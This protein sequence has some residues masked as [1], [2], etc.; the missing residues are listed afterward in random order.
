[1]ALSLAV[2]GIIQTYI[3]RILGVDYLT[4]QGFMKLW[5]TA[6]WVSAWGFTAGLAAFLV[7]FFRRL[8]PGRA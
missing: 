3:Q 1:M 7:D 2:A 6:F 8:A 5:Y 4:T